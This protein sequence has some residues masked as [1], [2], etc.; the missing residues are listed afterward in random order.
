MFLRNTA[1][2]SRIFVSLPCLDYL[3]VW[4]ACLLSE[5]CRGNDRVVPELKLL[6][7]IPD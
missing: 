2:S 6:Q 7:S 4:Y 1:Y 5:R 3:C